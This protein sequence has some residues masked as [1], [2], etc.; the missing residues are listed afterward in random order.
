MFFC[1]PTV[2][3]AI[4]GFPT[5]RLN[6]PDGKVSYGVDLTTYNF[7]QGIVDIIQCRAWNDSTVMGQRGFLIDPA[8]VEYH[9]GRDTRLNPNVQAPDYDGY[10]D[11]YLTECGL[12]L[13]NEPTHAMLYGVTG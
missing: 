11:E 4:D 6:N 7:S 9:Y 5:T 8:N 2:K 10:K 1:A 3:L 12:K 13:A